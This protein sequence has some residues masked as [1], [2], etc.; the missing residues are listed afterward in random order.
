MSCSLL[1]LSTGPRL[2]VTTGHHGT[3]PQ[4]ESF[5]CSGHWDGY[6]SLQTAGQPN[7]LKQINQWL[8]NSFPGQAI[9]VS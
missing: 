1:C 9:K 5:G 4:G 7:E 8:L 2:Q 3:I 6:C